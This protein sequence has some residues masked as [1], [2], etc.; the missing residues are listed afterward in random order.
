MLVRGQ[1]AELLPRPTEV[2]DLQAELV[3]SYRLSY[4]TVGEEGRQRLRILPKGQSIKA[5]RD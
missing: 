1:P 3:R 4:E 5:E 2:L